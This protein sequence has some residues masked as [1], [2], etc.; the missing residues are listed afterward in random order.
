MRSLEVLKF[1]D[2]NVTQ[3]IYRVDT[4]QICSE[5]KAAW[6]KVEQKNQKAFSLKREVQFEFFFCF[7]LHAST[8]ALGF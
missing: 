1:M 7:F 4:K 8:A 6:D 2:E 3:P 5:L